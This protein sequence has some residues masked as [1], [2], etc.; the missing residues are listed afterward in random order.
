MGACPAFLLG[1]ALVCAGCGGRQSNGGGF[2]PPTDLGGTRDA[3][4]DDMPPPPT[5][6]LAG[7]T[8][9]CTVPVGFLDIENGSS[10]Y[11]AFT[12][13]DSMPGQACPVHTST[14]E[15]GDIQFELYAGGSDYTIDGRGNYV[16]RSAAPAT[17]MNI[18]A[19]SSATAQA[20]QVIVMTFQERV[21]ADQDDNAER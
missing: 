9:I 2:S 5:F 12:D 6:D 21:F 18:V 4:V 14:N 3:A 19:T 10:R 1:G 17:L 20:D 13:A 8:P 15:L 11:A 16:I 7:A